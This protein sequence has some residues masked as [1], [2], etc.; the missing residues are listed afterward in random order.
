MKDKD[1]DDN[2][3]YDDDYDDD[4][5]DKLPSRCME[6]RILPSKLGS[7]KLQIQS[8]RIHYNKCSSV[9]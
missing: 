3:Y 7:I 5:D 2:D 8:P 6:S 4:D 1:D 9:Q